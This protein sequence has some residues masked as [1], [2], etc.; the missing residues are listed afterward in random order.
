MQSCPGLDVV[1]CLSAAG[2]L[3]LL[4][5]HKWKHSNPRDAGNYID[6]EC[7]QWFQWRLHPDGDMCNFTTCS[8]EM[9][10]VTLIIVC[11]ACVGI[12]ASGYCEFQEKSV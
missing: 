4:L 3:L 1:A 5:H 9:W 7:E 2:A 6:D 10:I 11:V 12:A 8:H